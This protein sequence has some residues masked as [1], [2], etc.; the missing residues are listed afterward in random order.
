MLNFNL[1]LWGLAQTRPSVS[2]RS[3]L[4]AVRGSQPFGIVWRTKQIQIWAESRLRGFAFVMKTARQGNKQFLR[5]FSII[6]HRLFFPLDC[7]PRVF[8]WRMF[9]D[10]FWCLSLLNYCNT[11]RNQSFVDTDWLEQNV[12]GVLVGV[13]VRLTTNG[14]PWQKKLSPFL[15]CWALGWF[16][17]STGVKTPVCR[18]KAILAGRQTRHFR[19][20]RCRRP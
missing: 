3:I 9:P 17:S 2:R 15:V 8:L 6:F 10:I 18:F 5:V 11:T 4:V 16:S 12:L 1:F 7:F 14:M 19:S 13:L 20:F